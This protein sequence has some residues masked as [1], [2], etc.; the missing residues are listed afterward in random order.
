MSDQQ[1]KKTKTAEEEKKKKKGLLREV[2]GD[3]EGPE[4]L[5]DSTSVTSN[6]N[7]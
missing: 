2:I 3:T 4:R 5:L 6:L 1:D 7:G